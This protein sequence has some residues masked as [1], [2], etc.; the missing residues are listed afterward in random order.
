M[1]RPYRAM[2]T[3]AV[4]VIYTCGPLLS[5][6][7]ASAIASGS[8]SNLNEATV[9]PCIIWGHDFGGVV[10]DM[11]VIFWAALITV[12]TGILAIVVYSTFLVMKTLRQ[13]PN[14]TAEP[15]SP[16]LGGLP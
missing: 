1:K 8:G 2:V 13:K 4:L 15:A 3:Y 11:F 12:P 14:H 7:L 16:S 9:H 6:W 10:Y 5:A